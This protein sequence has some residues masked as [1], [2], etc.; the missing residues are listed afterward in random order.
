MA[1]E[2]PQ[3]SQPAADAMQAGEPTVTLP[4]TRASAR[5]SGGFS[6]WPRTLRWRLILT[7]ATLLG[8]TLVVLGVALNVLIARALYT[9]EFGFF[10][11][12]SLAA[13]SASQSRFDTL[14][15]GRNTTC[16]DALPYE[17]AF[18]QAI[19]DPITVSH[20]GSIQGVYLLDG[21]GNVLAPISA[22]AGVSATHYLQPKR[23][24]AL[25]TKA[26]A[27]FD[28]NAT[29]IGS[30]QLANDGYFVNNRAAPYGVE[31]IALRY[32][33]TS[34][35]AAPRHA[36]LGYVEI[37]TTFTRTRLALGAIRLTLFAIMALV[38]A[39][40]LL[41]GAPLTAA[42]LRPLSRVTQAAR[43][44]AAGDLSQRVRLS[45]TDD[46]MG[47]LG[48]TFDDMVARI[49]AAFSARR[50]SEE[51]MR[52]F[53]ADASHELR[54]PLTSIRG[55]TDVLLRGAKDD[56][57]TTERVL[58]ATRREAERMSRLV[59]DLL[60]LARLDTGRPLESQ[61]LD[62][63]ALAG[64]CVD[65][66]RIL[67]GQR[68]V[69]MR[70]DGRGRLM[71]MGDPDRLK[72]VL[73]VLLDNALKYGRQTPDGWAR[74]SMGR[75]EGQAIITIED[76]GPGIASEDLPRI[77]ERFY[78]VERAARVRR[79]TGAQPAA[80]ASGVAPQQSSS[81]PMAEG[82]G[83][84]L[85]IAQAIAQAHGGSLTVQSAPGSGTAFT[86]ILPLTPPK[87]HSAQA[88]P[89]TRPGA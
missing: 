62:L 54:T 63:M 36:A 73:L 1:I 71:V 87:A 53:I 55:Y 89:A 69:M 76:N 46:E 24:A 35:C 77:F 47:Q 80:P 83:L 42:A 74:L 45:H 15:L 3:I 28:P 66:A 7:F 49:E 8:L 65:Q 5:R 20:P 50:R 25:A 23:L 81:A 37:V 38:F 39:L 82:S 84:G 32:Y 75:R 33:T 16:S 64:E 18:Q 14:T 60:T 43:R 4:T 29:A 11:N 85:A 56:P 70:T 17:T 88:N 59:N 67:A 10:Q 9:T 68:E 86:L 61:P 31:L 41:I 48:A 13:V 34:R 57:E 78:R 6:R 12:E 44:V 30:Q 58:L 22:Q 2:P 27:A 79:M 40:G 26:S 21:A 52:Q 51:R 19:A 72:Q